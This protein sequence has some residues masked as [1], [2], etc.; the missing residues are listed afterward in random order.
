M[1]YAS[2]LDAMSA[3]LYRYLNFN[4]IKTYVTKASKA[5]LPVLA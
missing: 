1:Q 3:D 5:S 4:E 2:R